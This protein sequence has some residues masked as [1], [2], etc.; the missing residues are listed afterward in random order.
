MRMTRSRY[1]S[2][3]RRVRRAADKIKAQKLFQA[4]ASGK[5]DLIKEMK[6]SH[7]NKKDE[8]AFYSDRLVLIL[9][10]DHCSK[11]KLIYLKVYNQKL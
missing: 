10:N 2:A 8:A 6:K 11:L 1:H 9:F 3:I 4:S 5:S 7:P